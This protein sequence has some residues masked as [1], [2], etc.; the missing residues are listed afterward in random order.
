MWL[1][2]DSRLSDRRDRI[3]NAFARIAD[4]LRDWR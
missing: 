4:S 2:F 1:V 3:W